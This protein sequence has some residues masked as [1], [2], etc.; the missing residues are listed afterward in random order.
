MK[1]KSIFIKEGMFSKTFSFSDKL[2]LVY[3]EF[4]SAG[5]TT[6]LRIMLYALGYN[7]PSTRKMKFSNCEI[8]LIVISEAGSELEIER[9]KMS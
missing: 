2:N 8:K 4:N 1:F 6:L 5:K 3:S 9:F 7:I